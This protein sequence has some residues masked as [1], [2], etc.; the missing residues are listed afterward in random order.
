MVHAW[1]S[2]RGPLVL[3]SVAITNQLSEY[4]ENSCV[5]ICGE[6]HIRFVV[7]EHKQSIYNPISFSVVL[8]SN[9]FSLIIENNDYRVWWVELL[10]SVWDWDFSWTVVDQLSILIVSTPSYF[11]T[12]SN[13][14]SLFC[15]SALTSTWDNNLQMLSLMKND[16]ITS[17]LLWNLLA[18]VLEVWIDLG[19]WEHP[20]FYPEHIALSTL[21]L[22][23]TS[24]FSLCWVLSQE[25]Y[26][27]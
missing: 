8:A 25:L 19:W 22:L 7:H 27:S 11:L 21:T 3:I 15:H 14:L 6:N 12:L 10:V 23:T 1:P 4:A 20:F 2:P 17:L 13:G 24:I 16:L 5:Y 9:G 26:R 18:Q